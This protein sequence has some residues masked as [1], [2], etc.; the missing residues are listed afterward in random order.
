MEKT[1]EWLSER[2]REGEWWRENTKFSLTGFSMHTYSPTGSVNRPSRAALT[3]HAWVS[4]QPRVSEVTFR[5]SLTIWPLSIVS[6][7]E[8]LSRD[9]V[10]RGR[11]KVTEAS[12]AASEFAAK[13]GVR[14][15]SRGTAF[16]AWAPP[17]QGA[18]ATFHIPHWRHGNTNKRIAAVLS[19]VTEGNT[20]ELQSPW[21]GSWI[22]S[23][24]SKKSE[25]TKKI[26][27]NLRR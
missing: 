21:R 6:A 16:A 20:T 23:H 24:K 13:R 3:L 1:S 12:D 8:A 11:V 26:W 22:L 19:C 9:R 2:E 17:I 14:G 4:P 27:C 15:E 25:N 7:V 18:V 10:A 5:A